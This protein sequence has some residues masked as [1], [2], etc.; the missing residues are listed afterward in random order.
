[1]SAESEFEKAVEKIV[2]KNIPLFL[3]E[4]EVTSVDKDTNTCNVDRGD[5]PELLD[6]RLESILEAGDDV[7]TIYPQ[8]GSKVL[9]VLVENSPTD[10]YVLAANKIEEIKGKIDT[11]EFLINADGFKIQR[12]ENNFKELLNDFITEVQKIVVVQGNSPDVPTLEEIKQKIN[13]ILK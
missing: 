13:Q 3:T 5:L 12:G 2:R 7:V 9:C 11:T 1:M 4:G 10:A 8:E 6:V